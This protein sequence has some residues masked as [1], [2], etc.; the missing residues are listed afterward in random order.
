MENLLVDRSEL[1]QFIDNLAKQKS[2]P[3]TTEARDKAIKTLDD[4]ITE[5]VLGGLNKHQ[6]LELNILLDHDDTPEVAQKFFDNAGINLE[7]KIT[8]AM[9]AFGVEF[10]GGANA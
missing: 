4:R 8:G 2:E 9:Q 1:G 5:A 7:Q 10:L 3:L 6:L